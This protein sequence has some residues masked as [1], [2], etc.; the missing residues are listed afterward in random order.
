MNLGVDT[1]MLTPVQTM[2]KPAVGCS[3]SPATAGI[4]HSGAHPV[5]AAAAILATLQE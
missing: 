4:L 1:P 2:S 3:T 5:D